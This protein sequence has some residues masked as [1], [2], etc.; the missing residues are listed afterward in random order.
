MRPVGL[1]AYPS[2]PVELAAE[3]QDFNTKLNA[4]LANWQDSNGTARKPKIVVFDF[5]TGDDHWLPFGSWL[6]DDF[7]NA[8]SSS[9]AT[10]E[11]IDRAQ[12][13]A[14]LKARHF[15]P[16]DEVNVT[17]EVDLAQ[18]LG[19]D[20]LVDGRFKALDKDL[21]LTLAVRRAVAIEHPRPVLL[22]NSRIAMSDDLAAR[23]GVPLA[24]LGPPP[25]PSLHDQYRQG[26]NGVTR[27]QCSYCP[28]AE[29]SAQGRKKKI[30]GT[31]TLSILI[32]PE[33]RT[34]DV[35]VTKSL[36][37]SL[38]QKAIDAVSQW[39]FEPAR[40]SSGAPVPVHSMVEVSFHLY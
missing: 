7:S 29:Y 2:N 11:V 31:V 38:D 21:G 12:L 22:V 1:G 9:G 24:S 15:Q 5:G 3:T 23:L 30:D 27:A 32:T 33:G 18:S 6:A 16:K 4:A 39:R 17:N 19:A 26:Q 10:F 35:Q 37:P 40:D 25:D 14:P 8:L 20:L 28:P 34:T 36:E 13:A